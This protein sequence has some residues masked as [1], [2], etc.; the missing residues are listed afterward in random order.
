MRNA[1]PE[2]E[3]Q[4]HVLQ[5]LRQ[6]GVPG[7]VY[8]HVP[9]GGKRRPIEAAILKGQGVRKGA[10]DLLLWHDSKA[11]ALE[12]KA[13]GGKATPEQIQFLQDMQRAGANAALATGLNQALTCLEQWG[14]LRGVAS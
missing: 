2:Q 14:L 13:E 10:S 4:K 11:F 7:L 6:R 1:R 3:I 8:I 12:L 5:H 9:N